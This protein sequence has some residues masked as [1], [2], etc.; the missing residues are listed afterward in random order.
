M[1]IC[2]R[3]VP[4]PTETAYAPLGALGYCLMRTH[5]LS[6]LWETLTL[7]KHAIVICPIVAWSPQELMT[8]CD[9]RG[10]CEQF[11]AAGRNL[12]ELSTS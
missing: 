2:L 5:F 12:Y 3:L 10:A 1:K 6:A 9:E 7:Q 4:M 11:C 8:H